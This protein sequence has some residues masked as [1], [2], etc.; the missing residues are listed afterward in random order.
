[1]KFNLRISSTGQPFGYQV[2]KPNRKF[3][4]GERQDKWEQW[5]EEQKCRTSAFEQVEGSDLI[6]QECAIRL[7]SVMRHVLDGEWAELRGV[8]EKVSSEW[9]DRLKEFSDAIEKAMDRK[10]IVQCV[11]EEI[12]R[13]PDEYV[14]F[15]QRMGQG[16]TR[17]SDDELTY[18]ILKH[19]FPAIRKTMEK[20]MK[21][22]GRIAGEVDL[23]LAA[24]RVAR[25]MHHPERGKKPVDWTVI[26]RPNPSFASQLRDESRFEATRKKFH[27]MLVDS[28]LALTGTLGR[29][30]KALE[31]GQEDHP[32]LPKILLARLPKELLDVLILM[33]EWHGASDWA[34]EDRRILTTFA[35]YWLFF[36]AN[37]SKAADR[38]FMYFTEHGGPWS[39]DSI[40]ALIKRFEEEHIARYVPRQQHVGILRGG[41]SKAQDC[42][43]LREWNKRFS[44][45]DNDSGAG[46]SLRVLSTDGELIKRSLM[47]LQRR[48]LTEKY[49]AYDPTSMRD[50][51]LPVDLDHIVPRDYFKFRWDENRVEGLPER[52]SFRWR[53]ETVG[54]SLGNFRWLDARENRRRKSGQYEPLEL[55]Y[56]ADL[57]AKDGPSCEKIAGEWNSIIPR[58]EDEKNWKWTAQRVAKFQFLIDSRTLDLYERL[59]K[60]SGIWDVFSAVE[61][62]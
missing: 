25:A 47:W 20:I 21:D 15:F 8:H 38:A 17:L 56:N 59:A 49:G 51:D 5:G 50:D 33:D 23:V 32:G 6:K 42:S 35:L 24:L 62:E 18:S 41:I 55:E 3:S 7:S 48:Y 29:L 58:K 45:I 16:G 61:P 44:E 4:M 1:M 11:P 31:Y 40:V 60:D 46:E 22:S 36:V 28:P 43:R 30:R 39:R 14:R 27:R 19:Q 53:R 52:D 10:I 9:R 13:S 57:V 54:E 34:E 2:H 26:G 37:D 12:I